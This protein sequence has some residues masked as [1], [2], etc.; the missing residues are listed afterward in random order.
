M[1]AGL[2]LAVVA[3]A[4]GGCT[5]RAVLTKPEGDPIDLRLRDRAERTRVELLAVTDS[6]LI[7]ESGGRLAEADLDAVDDLRV[8]GYQ[9]SK[10]SKALTMLMIVMTE[11]L[12][13]E[14]LSDAW[15]DRP[16][17]TLLVAWTAVTGFLMFTGDPQTRFAPPFHP[18]EADRLK[19]FCR[20]PQGLTPAQW[21]T[22]LDR[23]GQTEFEV[24]HGSSGP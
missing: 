19:L 3:L 1:K 18:K 8:Q 9:T 10:A 5:S 12:L 15:F 13:W 14:D 4:V 2:F 16:T 23:Y 21:Q 22:L 17:R 20:Y 24:L 7:V 11:A 6:T